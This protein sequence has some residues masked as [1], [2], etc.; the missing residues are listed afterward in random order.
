MK[1]QIDTVT[2]IELAEV[3][4]QKQDVA[5]KIP[6][7]VIDYIYTRASEAENEIKYDNVDILN[8][9]SKEAFSLYVY[10][11]T[12]Y[13]ADNNEKEKIKKVLINN[14]VKEQEML[15]EKYNPDNIFK[16]DSI[17]KVEVKE[18]KRIVKYSL[19]MRIKGWF[20]RLLKK[21]WIQLIQQ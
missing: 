3:L 6:K 1:Q 21:G 20:R 2:Y 12:K 5:E 4:K 7:E 8:I 17:S 16:N 18:E 14:E 9:I 10:L 15:R 19:F 11:F 13:V